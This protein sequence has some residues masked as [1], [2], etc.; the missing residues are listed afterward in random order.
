MIWSSM[1]SL[2]AVVFFL[3]GRHFDGFAPWPAAGGWQAKARLR[4]AIARPGS[5]SIARWKCSMAC[6]DRPA[7]T[8]PCPTCCGRGKI[9]VQGQ[10]R[11]ITT[12]SGLRIAALQQH[13]QVVI[14]RRV[15]RLQCDG[16]LE[17]LPRL[18]RLTEFAEEG[19][20]VDI[21][22]GI[23]RIDAHGLFVAVHRLAGPSRI[24]Q[25]RA[26][27]GVTPASQVGSGA[28]SVAAAKANVRRK[29]AI[30]SW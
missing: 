28:T 14:G 7:A 25:R 1:D 26:E 12:A 20:E 29:A 8:K 15:L 11:L 3:F 27:V 18:C 16:L 5:L 6:A 21:G 30:D 4:R 17:A 19:A 10:C 22:A 23:S 9:R 24:D 13:A 2:P